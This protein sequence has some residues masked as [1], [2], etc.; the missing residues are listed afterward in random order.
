M[1]NQPTPTH[2]GGLRRRSQASPSMPIILQACKRQQLNLLRM[3]RLKLPH[4]EDTE[5]VEASLSVVTL[6]LVFPTRSALA[7]HD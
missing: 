5:E 2:I 4:E 7:R 1:R 3:R 6:G